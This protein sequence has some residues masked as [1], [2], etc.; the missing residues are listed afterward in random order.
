MDLWSNYMS[1]TTGA[2]NNG[3][4]QKTCCFPLLEFEEPPDGDDGGGDNKDKV[5]SLDGGV[6]DKAQPLDNC[7]EHLAA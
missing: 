1:G 6:T 7:V 3:S 2:N 5:V 4:D